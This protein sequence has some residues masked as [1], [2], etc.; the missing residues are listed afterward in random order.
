[1]EAAHLVGVLAAQPQR[2]TGTQLAA[3]GEQSYLVQPAFTT[4][5]ERTRGGLEVGADF[6]GS[7]RAIV[8]P[9]QR[10]GQV[11]RRLP[12]AEFAHRGRWGHKDCVA[13]L[14]SRLAAGLLAFVPWPA[15]C[16][17]SEQAPAS[18]GGS[19]GSGGSGGLQLDAADVDAPNQ[20]P[21]TCSDA[22]AERAYVGCD[23][24]PT[25]TS[26]SV[27]NIFDFAVVVANDGLLP[28]EVV[29]ERAGSEVA[30]TTI[31]P[32]ALEKIYL[33]WVM[34]LK[35]PEVNEC[36]GGD[37]L[38]SSVLVRDGAYHLTSSAPVAA[39]QFSPLEYRGRN[40]P[41]GKSWDA[42][43]GKKACF[44][45]G[46]KHGCLSFSNDA[47]LLLP[48]TALTGSYRVAGAPGTTSG[49]FLTITATADGTHVEL[50]G[51][52]AAPILPFAGGDAGADAGLPTSASFDLDAGD[53]VQLASLDDGT[54]PGDFS[55]ALVRATRPVQL[56]T[57]SRCLN[58]PRNKPSCDHVEESVPPAETLGR[59]YFVVPPTNAVGDPV[60]HGVRIVGNVD[61]TT[62][63][64]PSGAPPGAPT[65]VDAGELLD[66]GVLG[67]P[68][69]LVA[70]HEVIV[71]TLLQGGSV[72]D[73]D[74]PPYSYQGD[75]ALGFAVTVE[76]YRDHYVFLAPNDYDVSYADV[77]LPEGASVSIDGVA[78]AQ[79]P[80][81]PSAVG[82]GYSVARFQLFDTVN[83]AHELV[84]SAPVGLTVAGYGIATSYFYAGGLDLRAI[85]PPPQ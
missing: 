83:G 64:Y 78:L 32:G 49:A 82:S 41:A 42:C 2:A 8:P 68:F 14:G 40:G 74:A 20:L 7:H 43:P 60:G 19:S 72:A 84:S 48:T 17:R 47:S 57:G 66:L 1:M 6:T 79:L 15:A 81:P 38:E 16:A 29:V 61:G 24:W 69:E 63:S 76:Q 13:R 34:E 50:E 9:E 3:L 77:I 30:R 26:N 85:A 44:L 4:G 23:F 27:W 28:A 11:P 67:A 39:Y 10:R 5:H 36:N 52:K 75:P 25:V 70:S 59:H 45:D 51:V 46:I 12:R 55:G 73:P 22:A 56:V 35:G 37:V 65:Q 33:P 58:Y 53:V 21:V 54:N 62:L 31:A 18:S 80:S 71:A